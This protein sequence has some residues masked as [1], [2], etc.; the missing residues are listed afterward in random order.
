LFIVR[1]GKIYTPHTATILEGIT[2]DSILT[3]CRDL[4]FV[5]IEQP[6]SRDQL[7]IADELFIS[8]T[9][10]EC[11]AVCEVDFRDI[12]TGKMGPVTKQIQQSFHATVHGQGKRSSDWLS[13]VNVPQNSIN[14]KI[15]ETVY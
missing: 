4:G 8:G 1:G 10:A 13:Y 2:R 12:G 9:A 14:R 7:Y 15:E 11:V 3:I 6:V 5:V